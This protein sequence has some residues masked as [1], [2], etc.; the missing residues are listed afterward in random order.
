M[1]TRLLDSFSDQRWEYEIEVVVD[2]D[3]GQKTVG[4]KRNDLLVKAKGKFV[5][6]VD[7]D[8]AI[9]PAYLPRILDTIDNEPKIDCVGIRGTMNVDGKP[10]AEFVHS[11][12][13]AGWYTGGDGTY[14][15]TPNHLNPIRR[16]LALDTMFNPS[17]S[18]GEDIDYSTRLR[19][20][21]VRERMIDEVVYIYNF[22]QR[23]TA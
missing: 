3:D 10:H 11:I 23:K 12:Q 21:L 9:T 4:R 1:L 19:P 18:I 17:L 2:L 6:F 13:C 5:S 16:D 20:L 7:D 15:R 14:Y 8:D 22:V